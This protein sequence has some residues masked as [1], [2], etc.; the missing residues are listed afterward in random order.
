M[1]ILEDLLDKMPGRNPQTELD[2]A[3]DAAGAV[4]RQAKT[5]SHHGKEASK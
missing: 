3:I 1:T 5:P 2:D 4:E